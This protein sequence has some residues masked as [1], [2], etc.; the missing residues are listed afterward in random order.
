MIDSAAWPPLPEAGDWADRATAVL[1]ELGYQ[2]T[3]RSPRSR[4]SSSATSTPGSGTVIACLGLH[5]GR[6]VVVLGPRHVHTDKNGERHHPIVAIRDVFTGEE[7]FPSWTQFEGVTALAVT[8]MD[9]HAVLVADDGSGAMTVRDL[10]GGGRRYELLRVGV[11]RGQ[12]GDLGIARADGRVLVLAACDDGA[13]RV[14][15]LSPSDPSPADP[16]PGHRIGVESIALPRVDGHPVVLSGGHLGDL[17]RR[18]A[19]T[20]SRT[21]WM[22]HGTLRITDI[23][24]TTID[25]HPVAVTGSP[26]DGVRLHDLASGQPLADYRSPGDDQEHGAG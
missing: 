24:V 18:D 21:A 23:A 5:E 12:V 3:L 22:R 13:L 9:G 10:R 1:D 16:S 20:G 26:Q 8:L 7:R 2:V 14:A 11:A 17:Y 15:D 19:R 4:G 6:P 25:R